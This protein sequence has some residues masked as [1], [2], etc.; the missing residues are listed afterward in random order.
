MILVI[1]ML[2]LLIALV[3]I[4]AELPGFKRFLFQISGCS[5]LIWSFS[6]IIKKIK[7]IAIEKEELLKGLFDT[8]LEGGEENDIL[9]I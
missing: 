1:Y 8:N 6:T 5:I 7:Q 4:N 9:G 2:L 3:R